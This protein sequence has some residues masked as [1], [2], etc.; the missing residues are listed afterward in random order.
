MRKIILG[1]IALVAVTMVNAQEFT[2]GDWVVNAGISLSD[3]DP[4]RLGG[5]IEH[6]L[7]NNVFNLNGLTFGLGAE[8]AFASKSVYGGKVSTFV[9]GV[10]APFHY[11]P[12][13]KL[14]LYTAPA[15]LYA[16]AKGSVAGT[17]RTTSTTEFG[18]TLIGARYFFSPS[19]GIFVELGSNNALGGA[20]GVSFKF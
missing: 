4:L 2:K 20:A 15:L 17:S 11:S 3:T 10:R 7:V 16:S 14:D 1:L 19:I 5:S 9:I 18:W 6:G 13:A 12:V 8:T